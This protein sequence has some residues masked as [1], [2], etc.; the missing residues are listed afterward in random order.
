MDPSLIALIR[1]GGLVVGMIVLLWLL[2]TDRL[3]TAGRLKSEIEARV[4]AETQR[5][6]AVAGWKAQAE[7]TQEVAKVS[8][9][10]VELL[11]QRRQ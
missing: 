1:D 10:A 6:E 2:I 7:A 3:P 11:R 5:D 4:K 9:E 8:T